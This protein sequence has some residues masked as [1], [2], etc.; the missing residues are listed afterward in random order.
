MK[1]LAVIPA[2][3]GSV[4]IKNKNINDFHGKPL[5]SWAIE[6]ALSSKL[7]TKTIVS[8]NDPVIAEIAA[9][10]GADVPFLRPAD[11]AGD[12]VGIEPVLRHTLETLKSDGQE[13]DGIVLL[14]P[15]N[16]LRLNTHLDEAITVFREKDVTSVVTVH[17]AAGNKNPHWILKKESEQK[18]CFFNNSSL[19]EIITRSQDLPVCYARNDIAYVIKPENLYEEPSNLY[20]DQVELFEMDD[21]FDGDINTPEDWHIAY[22]KFRRLHNL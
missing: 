15:T 21:F 8:T 1:I 16:P 6:T 5:I 12:T 20:G 11:L 4:R 22:D 13:Y 14:M 10:Y 3:S 17:Q 7:I 9:S 2:R 19:K 18:V